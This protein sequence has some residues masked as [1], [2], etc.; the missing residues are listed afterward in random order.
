MNEHRICTM[1]GFAARARK[2]VSGATAVESAIRSRKAKLVVLDKESSEN[3]KKNYQNLCEH[4]KIPYIEITNPG[5]AIG[6][7]DR[8]CLAILQKEFAEQIIK[9]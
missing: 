1:I 8:L 3:S 9:A 5:L 7:P 4:Y 2:C 6:K